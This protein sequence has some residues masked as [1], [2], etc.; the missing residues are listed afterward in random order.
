MMD[1]LEPRFRFVVFLGGCRHNVHI[2]HN[3]HQEEDD[4]VP[5]GAAFLQ[6]NS[7]RVNLIVRCPETVLPMVR[8]SNSAGFS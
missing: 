3:L 1:S 6:V 5:M 8:K 2:R 7:L 4:G